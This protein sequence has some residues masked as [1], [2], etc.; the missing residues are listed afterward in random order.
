M[1]NCI[2]WLNIIKSFSHEDSGG[3]LIHIV[4]IGKNDPA[5]KDNTHTSKNTFIEPR[6]ASR[7]ALQSQK[8]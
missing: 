7:R 5:H 8:H 1:Y 3:L 4:K 2:I 6:R